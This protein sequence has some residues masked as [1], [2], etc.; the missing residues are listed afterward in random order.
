L[1]WDINV[2]AFFNVE[3]AAT[4]REGT[5]DSNDESVALRMASKC[6]RRLNAVTRSS[7]VAVYSVLL[8]QELMT[9]HRFALAQTGGPIREV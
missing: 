1:S 5:P 3:R 9:H 8:V 2:S 4:E 7:T 6:P